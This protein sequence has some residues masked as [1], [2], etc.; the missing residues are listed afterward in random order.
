MHASPPLGGST[1]LPPHTHT[2]HTKPPACLPTS[3]TTCLPACL[4]PVTSPAGKQQ[5]LN[6]FLEGAADMLAYGGDEG[7][8]E[9]EDEDEEEGGRPEGRSWREGRTP[10]ATLEEG[11]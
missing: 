8:D 10:L 5:L 1:C 6:S 9:D 7:I 11:E 4:A 2:T 3:P